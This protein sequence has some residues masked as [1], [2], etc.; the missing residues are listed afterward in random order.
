MIAVASVVALAFASMQVF[1]QGA[2]TVALFEK[3][4]SAC[5]KSAPGESRAP[6]R[7]PLGQRTPESILIALTTGTMV[8]QAK[9]LGDDQKRALAEMLGGRPVGAATAGDA[10]AMPNRR[11]STPLGNPLEGP[12][13]TGWGA[14]LAN[15]RF[16]PA[17]GLSA[18][19]IPNLNVLL[20][21]SLR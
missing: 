11:E 7:E 14:N 20:A 10:S 8:E 5:H 16:Q 18:E 4:C 17:A 21:F 6:T 3:K 12:Q 13:W 15:T 9:E 2:Q 19:E 1:A